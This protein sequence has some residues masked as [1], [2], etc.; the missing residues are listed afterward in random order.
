VSWEELKEIFFS[1]DYEFSEEN[2]SNEI[3][4]LVMEER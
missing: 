2:K 4:E 3:Y 1:L